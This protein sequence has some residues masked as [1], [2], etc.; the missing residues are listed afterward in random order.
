MKE[1]SVN[2]LSKHILLLS[3]DLHINI[4]TIEIGAYIYKRRLHFYHIRDG[5]GMPVPIEQ[6]LTPF[7]IEFTATIDLYKEDK[8]TLGEATEIVKKQ[9]DLMI[10]KYNNR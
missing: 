9:L 10:Y 1:F 8:L 2:T 3:R 4:K 5:M 7:K 6:D